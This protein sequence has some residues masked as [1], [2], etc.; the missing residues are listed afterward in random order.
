MNFQTLSAQQIFS[1]PT[2]EINFGFHE[3]FF[4]IMAQRPCQTTTILTPIYTS[5][6]AFA[7]VGV[8]LEM[9]ANMGQRVSLPF[10]ATAHTHET[11]INNVTNNQITSQHR[12]K[13]KKKIS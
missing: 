7:N 12:R 13:K 3:F 9:F 11:T 5:A 10:P 1:N 6:Q 2:K 8:S 4:I